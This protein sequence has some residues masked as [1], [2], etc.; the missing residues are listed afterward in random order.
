MT[1][2]V[3][4]PLVIPLA[5]AAVGALG[6]SGGA[7]QRWVSVGGAAGLL[8]AA[9]ALL[10]EVDRVGHIVLHVG[11]WHA[12]F[13]IALVAD[14]FGALMVTLTAAAGLWCMIYAL[15][16]QRPGP[17]AS[18]RPERPFLLPMMNFL[19]MGVCGAF[20][21]G[22]LFNLYVWFEV[23]L[24][25]SFV[26]LTLGNTRAQLVGTLKYVVLNLL[27]SLTF[28]SA[29][30]IVYGL[31]GTLN[32]ADLGRATAVG[33]AGGVGASPEAMAAAVM[34]LVGFGIKAALVPVFFWL[35]AS[36]HTPSFAVSALCSALLTKVGVYSIFR[37]CTLAFPLQGE[38]L[39]ESGV[40]AVLAAVSMVVGVLGAASQQQVR[41]ILAFHSVSQMGYILMGL[42]IGTPAGMAAAVLFF[43]HHAVVK[44]NLFLIAGAMQERTGSN[45]LKDPAIA[46]LMRAS[47]L[48]AAAFLL[49]A[50]SLAGIPPMSGFAGKLG[51][52]ASGVDAGAWWLVG[53]AAGVGLLTTFS[54][55]KIWS[56]AF[57][58]EPGGEAAADGHGAVTP[59]AAGSGGLGLMLGVPV[60]LA[61]LTLVMGVAAGPLAAMCTRAGAQLADPSAYITA[62]SPKRAS[63]VNA[64]G[65]AAEAGGERPVGNASGGETGRAAP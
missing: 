57:W 56:E 6:R 2:L 22:D 58:R 61:G 36:Y 4:L 12:P 29:A 64:A 27:S 34:L 23:L 28:L 37:L 14:R 32:F 5:A 35:P 62:V 26:L 30:G 1:W 45:H 20:L 15:R 63:E 31:Y 51:L 18:G 47:P 24:M 40:L 44:S 38:A 39:R 13:G 41:R 9:I 3:A 55:V 49:T 50:L 16:E 54:M 46:G 53:I 11:N 21:T 33:G 10:V 7:W 65:A 19:L 17:E 42:A 52:I 59:A 43:L 60:A 25:A 8:G 48:L